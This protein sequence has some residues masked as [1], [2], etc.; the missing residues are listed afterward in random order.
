MNTLYRR[1]RQQYVLAGLLAFVAAVNVLFF[2]ILY[3][4][5]RSEYYRLRDSTQKVR[6]AIESRQQSVARLEKLNAQL[7]TSA[8]DRSRLYT[9]H[10]IPREAGWSEILKQLDA[11]VQ[12]TGVKNTRKNYAISPMQQYGLYSVTIT[13]PVSGAYSNIIDLI[14][15]IEESETFYIINSID[16]RGSSLPGAADVSL[17]LNLE[18]FFYQ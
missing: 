7:E 13:I 1:Q 11:M 14:K 3:R 9:L 8:Q 15:Q 2:L 10:F 18:T 4:P 12:S 16:V 17:A 6:A 5:A